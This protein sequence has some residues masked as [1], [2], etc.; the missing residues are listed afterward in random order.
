MEI[1]AVT[2]KGK[3]KQKGKD[4]KGKGKGKDGKGKGVSCWNSN[5]KGKGK[6]FSKGTFNSGGKGSR[7]GSFQKLDP[8]QCA[9]CYKFGHRKADCRKMQSDKAAGG[10]RQINESSADSVDNCS[11]VYNAGTS[12]SGASSSNASA[13]RPNVQNIGAVSSVR[14]HAPYVQHLTAFELYS[15]ADLSVHSRV[16]VVQQHDM[17]C[18]DGDDFWT[19][20]PFLS[21]SC[22][23][24]HICTIPLNCDGGRVV[25][26]LLDSG[27][28]SSVLPL[29]C[30]N[31]GHAV[32]LILPASLLMPKGRLSNNEVVEWQRFALEVM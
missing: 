21:A 2:W 5:Q 25:E 7:Q 29:D 27:A 15:F 9:Y 30:A 24:Q 10:V 3:G 17:S 11:T 32:Q 13:N 6:E 1:D 8:N 12:T 14:P 26:I 4:G 18:T 23:I 22:D 19:C 28:D 31:L 16:C 20:S